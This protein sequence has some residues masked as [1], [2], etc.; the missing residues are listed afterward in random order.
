M[1]LHYMDA[2]LDNG[3]IIAQELVMLETD[4]TIKSLNDKLDKTTKNYLKR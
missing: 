1:T 2:G 4:E 3:N